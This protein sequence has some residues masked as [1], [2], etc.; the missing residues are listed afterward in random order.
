MMSQEPEYVRGKDFCVSNFYFYFIFA[1]EVS[2]LAAER[3][4]IWKVV[5]KPDCKCGG[6]EEKPEYSRPEAREGRKYLR[7]RFKG[8]SDN[9][10]LL[11]YK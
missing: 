4:S 10:G 3:G 5:M 6:K 1:A 9:K 11:I 7:R 8:K 2:E